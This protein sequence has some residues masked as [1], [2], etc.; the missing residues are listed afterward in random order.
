MSKVSIIVPLY[1]NKQ[2]ITKAIDSILNQSYTNWEL[3]IINDKSTDGVEKI[4]ERYKDNDKITILTNKKNR[5]CYFS[6]NRGIKNSVGEYIAR[7][8]SDD[9]MH[10]DK[11]KT[12][13]EIFEKHPNVN[14][15][16]CRCK[17]AGKIIYRSMGTAMMRREIFDKIG[18]YDSVRIAADSEFKERYFKFYGKNKVHRIKSVMYFIR[19]R[20]DSLSRNPKT[21]MNSALRLRYKN[22]YKRWHKKAKNKD[23]YIDFPLK[24][25]KFPAPKEIR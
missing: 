6:L 3:I 18:Y 4:L 19:D 21:G 25:R 14:M 23:L 17:S 2:Y 10:K 7:L 13:V 15:I 1:N 20:P 5:G 11:I 9:A 24:K 22:N 16:F 8:D 12:Q